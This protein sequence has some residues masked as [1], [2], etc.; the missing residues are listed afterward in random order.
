M[1]L[2]MAEEGGFDFEA[3]HVK[4]LERP[5]IDLQDPLSDEIFT[6]GLLPIADLRLN[7]PRLVSRLHNVS[8]GCQSCENWNLVDLEFF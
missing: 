1:V 6:F 5:R 3:A 7:V 8:V 4:F 2:E